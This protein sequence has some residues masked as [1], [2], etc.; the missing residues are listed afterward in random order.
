MLVVSTAVFAQGAPVAGKEFKQ[1]NPA[2]KV[3]G[4]QVEVLEFFS[5][6]C[7]HCDAFEPILN[8]WLS[9]KPKDVNFK[10]VPAVFNKR[11]IPLAQLYYTLEET[12]NLGKLHGKVYDAIHRQG[13]NL[14]DRETILEWAAAQGVDMK[15]FEATYDSFSVGTQTQRAMQ[16]TRNYRIPGTPYMVVNGKYL[17]GPS[18]V[19]RSDGRG[20]DVTRFVYVLNTL[21]DYER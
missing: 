13:K 3:T 2:Q 12:D 21:I 1:L 14:S 20:V 18:M 16:M 8:N 11:M 9:T 17:T 6:A 10:H 15:K 4:N 19:A 5:Y 7:S